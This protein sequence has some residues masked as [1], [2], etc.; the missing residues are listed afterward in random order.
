VS[1][2]T[3]VL[4]GRRMAESVMLDSCTIVRPGSPVTDPNTGVVTN[5]GPTVYSGKVKIQTY[6][7]QES[8]PQAGGATFTVQRYALHIPVGSYAPE[9]GDVATITTAAADANMVGRKYRVVALL[10][11][12]LATAYRLGVEQEV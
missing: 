1:A 7:A 11:K 6:E 5:P 4:R 9:V 8:N 2:L 12:S 10:N 3:A